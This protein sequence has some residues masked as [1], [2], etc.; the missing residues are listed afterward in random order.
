MNS[1]TIAGRLGKD[2]EQKY[3]TGGE[4][5]VNFSVAVSKGKNKPAQWFR[6]AVW[7]KYGEAIFDYL[8]KGTTVAVQGELEARQY[9]SNGK[10]G[11]SLDITARQ[12]TLLGGGQEAQPVAASRAPGD[13]SDAFPAF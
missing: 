2:A 8:T 6:V 3:T 10:P 11:V 9:E 5:V 13:D 7:G 4:S 1:I 12:V